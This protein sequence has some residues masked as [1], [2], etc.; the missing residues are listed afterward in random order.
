[1]D[2]ESFIKCYF[3]RIEY[4]GGRDL[5][6]E[7]LANLQKQHLK[8]IP[9]ENTYVLKK[10]PI[11]LTKERLFEKVITKK[12]GGFCFEINHLFYLLLSDLGY[13]ITL[14][15]GI[16]GGVITGEEDKFGSNNEHI[17]SLVSLNGTS[18]IVDV[19]FGGKCACQP[20]PL[21]YNKEFED[22]NGIF[23]YV[24]KEDGNNVR[25][26]TK[27]K[28]IIDIATQAEVQKATDEWRGMYIFSLTPISIEDVNA[29]M[30]F[31]TTSD[32]SPFT[33]GFYMFRLTDTGKITLVGNV[34]TIYT[35]EGHVK[36]FSDR[37]EIE[38]TSF[39]HELS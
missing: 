35:A 3:E 22:S 11:Y 13:D 4:S 14:L 26:E 20:L 21:V 6:L 19:A 37:K 8:A 2:K 16:V 39:D 1:M 34:L 28:M 25:F 30:K 12:R 17:I 32:K 5:N 23:R 18:Y 33:G 9:F 24:L 27:P 29:P 15:G 31:H 36:E 10:I 38:E 7:N